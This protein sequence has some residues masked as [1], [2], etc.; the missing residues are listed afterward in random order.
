MNHH[1]FVALCRN[2]DAS[3]SEIKRY[4]GLALVCVDLVIQ[5]VPDD[6][7]CA[8]IVRCSE[9]FAGHEVV[10]RYRSLAFYIKYKNYVFHAPILL[11]F[12]SLFVMLR[13]DWTVDLVNKV[14]YIMSFHPFDCSTAKRR[15]IISMG[16]KHRDP[17][18]RT[19][20]ARYPA[21]VTL[22]LLGVPP[23]VQCRALESCRTK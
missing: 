12:H 19:R 11:N 2:P 7:R 6:E 4:M 10:F 15:R 13:D 5:H 14:N 17:A 16:M 3:T 22:F 8:N 23:R 18:I 21:A 20:F 9:W 1:A